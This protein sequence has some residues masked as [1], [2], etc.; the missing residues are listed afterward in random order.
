MGHIYPAFQGLAFHSN[1]FVC[2]SVY[3]VLHFT[4][5][6]ECMTLYINVCAS[7]QFWKGVIVE[8]RVV[9]RACVDAV[10]LDSTANDPLAAVSDSVHV[11]RV[12]IVLLCENHTFPN[13]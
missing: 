13:C 3:T 11:C 8:H 7:V 10:D 1:P 2:M 9:L 4:L 5:H 12:Y 6:S